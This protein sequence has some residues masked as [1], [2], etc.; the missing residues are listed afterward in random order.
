MKDIQHKNLLFDFYG[1]LL[2]DKQCDCFSMHYMDDFS[3][4]EIG[5]QFGITPQAVADLLKRTNALLDKYEHKLGLVEKHN[6]QHI[7]TQALQAQ[8]TALAKAAKAEGLDG[9]VEIIE[10]IRRTIMQLDSL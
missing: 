4:V 5:E 8:L 10:N 3:L 7:L 1:G 6:N 9:F 2:T